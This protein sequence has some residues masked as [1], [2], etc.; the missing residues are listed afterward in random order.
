MTRNE[1]KPLWSHTQLIWS[2]PQLEDKPSRCLGFL[3]PPVFSQRGCLQLGRQISSGKAPYP[4]YPQYPRLP[5]ALAVLSARGVLCVHPSGL[6]EDPA[7]P[8]ASES[9]GNLNPERSQVLLALQQGL[10]GWQSQQDT[11]GSLES[12]FSSRLV[13]L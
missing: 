9:R 4:Q 8:A 3:S 6:L 5:R 11:H 1:F 12:F 13:A 7:A 2:D 10:Q